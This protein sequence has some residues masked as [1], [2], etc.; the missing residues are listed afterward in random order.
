LM[1]CWNG[2]ERPTKSVSLLTST[3]DTQ[4]GLACTHARIHK[5]THDGVVL[6]MVC[7]TTATASVVHVSFAMTSTPRRVQHVRCAVGAP[8]PPVLLQ[9][10]EKLRNNTFDICLQCTCCEHQGVYWVWHS[11]AQRTC[12]TST[13]IPSNYAVKR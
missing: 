13:Q 6:C 2:S 4:R 1:S 3:T 12:T 7:P 8:R 9:G 10:N 5:G 11:R